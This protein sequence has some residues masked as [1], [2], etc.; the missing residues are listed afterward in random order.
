MRLLLVLVVATHADA[1][2]ERPLHGSAGAGSSLAITGAGNDH[3]RF[4]VALDLKPKSRYGVSV[5]WRQFDT[6]HRGLLVG[7]VVYEGAAARPRLV[8]DLHAGAGVDLDRPAP[9]VVAGI[10]ATLAVVGPLALVFDLSAYLILDGVDD[11]RLQLAS[12]TLVALRW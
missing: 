5:G 1:R 9:L 12:S 8:L 6:D 4:D 11:S 3:L 10:R 7:G 2:A